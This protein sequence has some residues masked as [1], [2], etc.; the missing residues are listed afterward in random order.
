[1]QVIR[2]RERLSQ[3]A[4]PSTRAGLLASLRQPAVRICAALRARAAELR[5]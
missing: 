5:S 2:V 1:V 4:E 3:S